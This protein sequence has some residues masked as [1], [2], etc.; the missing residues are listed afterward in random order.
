MVETEEAEEP[1]DILDEI[2]D[3]PMEFRPKLSGKQMHQ[4]YKDTYYLPN[5]KLRI[6]EIPVNSSLNF[7]ML[8]YYHGYFNIIYAGLIL[9]GNLYQILIWKL[10]GNVMIIIKFI[11]TILFCITEIFRLNFGYKGNINQ[12]FPELIAFLIQT[13]LFSLPFV[14][15]PFFTPKLPHEDC[16]YIISIIFLVFEWIIGFFLCMKFSNT[17]S[18]AYYRRTAPI[19]DKKFKRKYDNSIKSSHPRAVPLGMRRLKN[20]EAN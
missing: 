6:L 3:G 19:L 12:S 4:I 15:V 16:M 13:L 2:G 8:L 1:Q 7:Q 18:A 17:M 14:I 9:L 10:S 20:I 11:L 5:D